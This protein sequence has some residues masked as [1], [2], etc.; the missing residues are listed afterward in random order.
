MKNIFLFI[1]LI[2]AT[3]LSGQKFYASV[4]AK[5]ILEDSYLSV[6]FTLENARGTNFKAPSFKNFT[7]VQGPR[8]SQ[9]RSNRNGKVSSSMTYGYSLKPKKKGNLRIS[10][11]SINVKG[12]I[13]KTKPFS[14]KVLKSTTKNKPGKD[15]Y[16]TMEISDSI[17]YM[18]QQ[19]LVD[20]KLYYEVGLNVRSIEVKNEDSFDGFFVTPIKD[21]KSKAER[22]IINGKE[23]VTQ[24]VR[25]LALFPQTKGK[26]DIRAANFVVF[27]PQKKRRGFYFNSFREEYATTK[28]GVIDVRNLPRSEPFFSGAIGNYKINSTTNKSTISTD[29]SFTLNITIS[30]DGDPKLITPP[31]LNLSD[32]L[33]VY[34]PNLIQE[35]KYI[36]DG[37]Q[38]HIASY[39]YLIVP[40]YR[41]KYR[42]TPSLV[43]YN[44]DSSSFK[45]GLGSSVLLNVIQG[46]GT[47]NTTTEITL[48][49]RAD[50][51]SPIIENMS[52]AKAPKPFYNS[53]S[54]WLLFSLLILGFPLLVLYKYFVV[55]KSNIDPELLKSQKAQKIAEKK[56]ALAKSC[57]DSNEQ[58]TFYNEISNAILGYASDRLKIP[59]SELSSSN[60]TQELEKLTITSGLIEDVKEILQACEMALFAGTSQADKMQTMYQKSK[61]TLSQIE[62]ELIQKE[63]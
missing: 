35:R 52:L 5:E 27:F 21:Y 56:L 39:E 55:K 11:A 25:K 18:G 2:T 46:T 3:V 62:M 19:I 29:Q 33:E 41:G 54:H 23:Y 49:E 40:K 22:K 26:F 50:K 58:K 47:G 20:Y 7:I 43:F 1:F 45:T 17:A 13:L 14:I 16:V 38:K 4:D 30:G 63:S 57:M 42:I 37:M 36:D 34:E 44:P 31:P 15:Y 10:S 32:S 59:V 12:K 6:E 51:M 28:S 53:I 61:E 60:I 24:T 8:T 9:E 48:S